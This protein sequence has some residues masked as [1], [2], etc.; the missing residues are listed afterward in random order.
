LADHAQGGLVD[1]KTPQG[2]EWKAIGAEIS[3]REIKDIIE[4]M[5]NKAK[6]PP[7]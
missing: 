5:D 3:K 2:E 1:L 4:E 6:L 7:V